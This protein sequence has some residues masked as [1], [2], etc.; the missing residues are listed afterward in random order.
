MLLEKATLVVLRDSFSEGLAERLLKKEDWYK[1]QTV[2]DLSLPILEESKKLLD[3][4]KIKNTRDPYVL[5]N[6]SPLCAFDK[7]L[8]KVKIFLRKYPN[9]QPI[10]FPA[11]LGEDLPYF[12]KLQEKIPTLECFDWTTVGVPG[13]MKFL[14]FAEAGIGA[15]LHFLY[16]LKFF[17]VPYEVLV[18]N[19]KNQVN[20][21]D[22][23]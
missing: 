6:I 13:T 2:G 20:L 18:N 9:A 19:H 3:K 23:D 16:P 11:H 12:E 21:A 5:V 4:G 10:Y 7:A 15:R 22:I 17:G 1:V 14:Y 8:K